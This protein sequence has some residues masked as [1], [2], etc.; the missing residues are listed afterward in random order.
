M[1]FFFLV[2]GYFLIKCDTVKGFII[3][4]TCIG[5]VQVQL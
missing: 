5:E 1:L 2:F 3:F 4:A